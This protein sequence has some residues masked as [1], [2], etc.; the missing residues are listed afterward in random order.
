MKSTATITPTIIPVRL[1]GFPELI[2]PLPD[3]VPPVEPLPA[4][5]VETGSPLAPME[6]E[7]EDSP[8][9]DDDE[10]PP[11]AAFAVPPTPLPPEE[12]DVPPSTLEAPP[13]FPPTR[14]EVP[15]VPVPL[16]PDD[17]ELPEVAIVD[18]PVEG[19]TTPDDPSEVVEFPPV[20]DVLDPPVLGSVLEVPED[21]VPLDV[22]PLEELPLDEPPVEELPLDELPLDELP[23]E[24]L[25]LEE[26][27]LDVP[28][29][30]EPPLDV[31]PLL[32]LLVDAVEELTGAAAD[33]CVLAVEAGAEALVEVAGSLPPTRMVRRGLRMGMDG[34]GIGRLIKEGSRSWICVPSTRARASVVCRFSMRIPDREKVR[35]RLKE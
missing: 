27:P 32:P 19:S 33:D 16:V 4:L 29:L 22:L 7:P 20:A 23:L 13:E 17:V 12:S 1:C 25:P 31:P 34:M 11:L 28:P 8:G 10:E 30:D 5:P 15:D 35:R 14:L 9:E 24:E 3:E 26:L 6:T 18:V 21:V 2:A